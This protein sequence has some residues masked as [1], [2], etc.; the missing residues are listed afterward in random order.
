MGPAARIETLTD[1]FTVRCG[2]RHAGVC[3][4]A[5]AYADDFDITAASSDMSDLSDLS[6]KCYWNPRINV[7]HTD[8]ANADLPIPAPLTP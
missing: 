7:C 5:V 4:D 1:H 3:R 2:Q 8:T 6:D